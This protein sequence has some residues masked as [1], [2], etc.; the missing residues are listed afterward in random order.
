MTFELEASQAR[1]RPLA[2]SVLQACLEQE[3]ETTD[4]LARSAMPNRMSELQDNSASQ[5]LDPVH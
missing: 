2:Q 5:G 1:R 3:N 4:V